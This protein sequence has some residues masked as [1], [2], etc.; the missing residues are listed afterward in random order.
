LNQSW[1]SQISRR[2][3]V[4]VLACGLVFLGICVFA[5]G[6]RYK[7]SL[8]DPPHAVSRCMPAAKL[9]TGR[10]GPEL[11]P[12]S[13]SGA[14]NSS[15]PAALFALTLAFFIFAKSRLFPDFS[16]MAAWLMPMRLTPSRIVH[17]PKFT[18]PPPHSR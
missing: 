16:R 5:W 7:L 9:L 14:A 3:G 6:L 18:R 1:Q 2:T 8:Y 12:I 15:A 13:L 17:A 11:P 4:R 10:E